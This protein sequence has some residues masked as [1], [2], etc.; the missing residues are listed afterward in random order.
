MVSW[1]SFGDANIFT[2]LFGHLTPIESLAFLAVIVAIG[3][4]GVYWVINRIRS[5]RKDPNEPLTTVDEQD[6]SGYV[7][8]YEI[9]KEQEGASF[10]NFERSNGTIET[11]IIGQPF[12]FAMANGELER[13]HFNPRGSIRCL[14]PRK[15]FKKYVSSLTEI[16]N[17]AAFTEQLIRALRVGAMIDEPTR[18]HLRTFVLI[19]L[20][21]GLVG[22]GL[23]A[24]TI[25]H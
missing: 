16:N 5:H 18:R 15:L 25:H 20:L 17:I 23:A 7:H 24:A 1:G 9:S 11:R 10:L 22:L 14:D 21:S 6:K 19:F 13:H 12:T 3:L 4:I 2:T 8:I